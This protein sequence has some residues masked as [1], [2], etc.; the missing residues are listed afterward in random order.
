MVMASGRWLGVHVDLLAS[1]L[2]GLVA[3]AAVLISQDAGRYPI[4]HKQFCFSGTW[5]AALLIVVSTTIKTMLPKASSLNTMTR[6]TSLPPPAPILHAPS[7]DDRAW[8]F[9]R[10]SFDTAG[11]ESD[12]C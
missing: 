6:I 3:I 4:I 11:S 1:L 2:I 8:S 9:F 5:N 12:T 10:A 7:L